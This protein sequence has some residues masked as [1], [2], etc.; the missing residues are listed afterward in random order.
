M[1]H[2]VKIIVPAVAALFAVSVY[3]NTYCPKLNG[4]ETFAYANAHDGTTNNYVK[5]YYSNGSS[6]TFPQYL[7]SN[8]HGQG[9]IEGKWQIYSINPAAGIERFT[10]NS[11]HTVDCPFS[12]IHLSGL[13]KSF[14]NS[15]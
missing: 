8:N 2:L 11:N 4:T 12:L 15:L 7:P 14:T 13:L 5:C 1:K 6:L 9:P 10:C 3:A